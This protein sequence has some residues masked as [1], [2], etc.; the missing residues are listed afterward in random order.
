MRFATFLNDLYLF[1]AEGGIHAAQALL[2]F[3]INFGTLF[4]PFH[5]GATNFAGKCDCEIHKLSC[6]HNKAMQL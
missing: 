1:L 3:N 5:E 4:I 6:L 2:Q